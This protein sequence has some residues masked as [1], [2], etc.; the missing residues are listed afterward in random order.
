MKAENTEI[1][2]VLRI[3]PQGFRDERGS[4]LETYHRD[5]YRKAGLDTEF[6]QDNRSFSQHHVLRG[7]HY[8]VH[9]PQGHLVTVVHGTV[10]DVGVD[11]RPQSPTFGSWLGFTLSADEPSQIYWPPGIAHGFCVLSKEA[12]ILYKCTNFYYSDDEGGLL[13]NDPD[14]GIEWPITSPIVKERDAAFPR[15]R[16]IPPTQLPSG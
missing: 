10:F 9:H 6:V 15:L 8:Q 5:R 7:M 12:E 3:I 4:F 1:P 13:W 2:G 14:I 11:L 16:D